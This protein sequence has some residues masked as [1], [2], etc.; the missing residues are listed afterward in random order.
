MTSRLELFAIPGLPMVR[1]GDD[2]PA[3][4]L[5]GLERAG[6]DLCDRDVVVVAQK[7]VSKAEGRTVDLADVVPSP[8]A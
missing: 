2:L 8:A 6:L 3:L 5:A 7:I 1:A 4:I